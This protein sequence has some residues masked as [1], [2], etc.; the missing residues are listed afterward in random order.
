M[1]REGI[2][3]QRNINKDFVTGYRGHLLLATAISILAVDFNFYPDRFAKTETYGW[4]IMDA[5]V[6]SFIILQG[7]CSSHGKNFVGNHSLKKVFMSSVPIFMVGII[8]L[9]T[10]TAVGYHKVVP[11][12]GVHWNFFFTFALTKMICYSALCITKLPSGLLALITISIHQLLLSKYGMAALIISDIR[13]NLF[14]ANKEGICSLMGFITLYFWGV[15]LGQVVWKQGHKISDY[16]WQ[17]LKMCLIGIVAWKC[18]YFLNEAVQ[19]ASRRMANL[20]Y[21]VWMVALTTLQLALHLLQE[22]IITVLSKILKNNYYESLLW[23]SLNSNALFYFL[24]SNVLTGLVNISMNPA[25]AS[26]LQSFIIMSVY[27]MTLT[28][29]SVISCTYSFKLKFW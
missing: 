12:Y 14:E 18:M 26:D 5:G 9:V 6:G 29:S 28:V 7:L 23:K 19:P 8:R 24:L 15:Q 17:F 2:V 21:C 20:T 1:E 3:Y 25:K 16:I 10:T 13:T 4:S 22:I 11:E 27:L